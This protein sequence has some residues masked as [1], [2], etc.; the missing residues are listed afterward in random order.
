MS[1][2]QNAGRITIYGLIIRSCFERAEQFGYLGTTL[3]NQNSIQIEV[4][5]CLLSFGAFDLKVFTDTRC[6][7]VSFGSIF[8]S[9]NQKSTAHTHVVSVKSILYRKKTSCQYKQLFSC[10][11]HARTFRATVLSPQQFSCQCAHS[12]TVSSVP[13]TELLHN[14]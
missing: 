8:P 3:T 14:Y 1:G 12:L 9:S 7:Q 10:S 11:A 6:S 4:T 13:P 2:D 5:E